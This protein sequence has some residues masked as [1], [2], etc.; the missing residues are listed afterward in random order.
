[1]IYVTLALL[2]IGA[3]FLVAE[4]FIPGFGFF[5]ISGIVLII[6]SS[7]MTIVGIKY[8]VFMVVGE[9]AALSLFMFILLQYVKKSQLYGKII[10]DETLN[11]E[12]K[13]IGG[14]DYFF[15]KEGIT[16]TP[17]KPFG[18][19]DFNGVS[20]EV[21]SDGSYIQEKKKVKVIDVTKNK[22]IVRQLENYNN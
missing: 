4:A 12:E 14:T 7:I 10:L 19:V 15:G 5:G 18:T 1:M 16:K 22:I 2:I 17:L 8:G 6:V 20:I 3:V 9:V 11:Y 13:E 21:Y